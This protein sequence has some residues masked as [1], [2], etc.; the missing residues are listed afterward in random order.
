MQSFVI[1]DGH[2]KSKDEV[3]LSPLSPAALYGRGVFTTLAVAG[4]E[5]FLW[6]KHLN[7]LLDHTARLGIELADSDS[8]QLESWLRELIAVND[9]GEGRARIT[10]FDESADGVWD[11]EGK[12]GSSVLIMTGTRRPVAASLN[13]TVSPYSTSSVSPLAGIKSTNYVENLIAIEEA[14]VR[15]FDEAIRVNERRE[16]VGGCLSNLFWVSGETIFTPA[17]SAGCIAGTTRA[18]LMEHF[19]VIEST[20]DIT[21]VGEADAIYLTSAG[22]G[23]KTV[24]QLDDRVIPPIEHPL[25]AFLRF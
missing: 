17:V 13:V 3:K 7:R 11:D 18:F 1:L 16:V 22:M 10:I 23:V 8:A 24:R 5:P 14:R 20:A 15:G 9:V 19:E 12:K 6:Q 4:G 2:C 25:G 21:R